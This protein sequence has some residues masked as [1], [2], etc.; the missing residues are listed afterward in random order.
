LTRLLLLALVTTFGYADAADCHMLPNSAVRAVPQA[1]NAHEM[2]GI[3]QIINGVP[4]VAF[5]AVVFLDIWNAEGEFICSGTLVSPSTI[6]TAGHCVAEVP[7]ISISA[8]FL[9]DGETAIPYDVVAYA[10]EPDY[11]PPVADLAMLLLE[12]PVVGVTP[13]PLATRRSRPGTVG[14]IVG[15]GTDGRGNLGVKEMGTVRLSRCPKRPTLGLPA[16]AL[17]W[18]VCWR[19]R[20]WQQDTCQGD[21]GGPLLIGGSLAGVTS[22][23]DAYCAGI[24]SWDT[25]V[26]PFV[27]WIA[28]LLR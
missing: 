1:Q 22:A 2:P 10:L 6:L 17:S 14:T 9:P 18:S 8:V 3:P 21:S 20:S 25:S 4:T 28:S 12:A 13:V 23:G 11:N 15:Y 7:P 24:L 27:P 26:A 5:P 16:G 19:R